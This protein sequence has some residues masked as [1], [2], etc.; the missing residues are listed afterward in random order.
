MRTPES[1]RELGWPS[2]LEALSARCRLPAG[3]RAALALGFLPDPGTAREAL[4]RVEE[5][6]S[7]SE[8][9]LSLPLSGVGSV[10]EHLDRVGK[11]GVLEPLALRDC[12]APPRGPYASGLDGGR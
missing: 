3:G 6:R 12:A 1:L 7:L 4:R 9:G 11:G 10:E 2:L 5:A 8:E